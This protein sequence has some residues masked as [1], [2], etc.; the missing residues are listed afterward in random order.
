MF[1]A[2]VQGV[3]K[4][5][6]KALGMAFFNNPATHN[7][8]QQYLDDTKEYK[9]KLK[10]HGVL[11]PK[12]MRKKLDAKYG[13][14]VGGGDMEDDAWQCGY[15][16]DTRKVKRPPLNSPQRKIF[17]D[18]SKYVLACGGNGSGKTYV[19][20]HKLVRHCV[21]NSATAI[22]ISQGGVKEGEA[23][24]GIWEMLKKEILPA[25]EKLINFHWGDGWWEG[26]RWEGE[27]KVKGLN[28]CL[29]IE[30][31][32][33]ENS[34]IYLATPSSRRSIGDMLNGYAPDLILVDKLT[35]FKNS[36][37]FTKAIPSVQYLATCTPKSPR[38]WV[39]KIFIERHG[40]DGKDSNN[41]SV[42][43]LKIEDNKANL[44]N[45]FYENLL[46][47]LNFDPIEKARHL[48]GK[49]IDSNGK[50]PSVSS[51]RKKAQVKPPKARVSP[52]SA[53]PVPSSR[54]PS[55]SRAI[56]ARSES[57]PVDNPILKLAG[58]MKIG[59]FRKAFRDAFGSTL[60]VYKGKQYADDGATIGSVA[61]KPI[62]RG[63]KFSLSPQVKVGR[64]E[65]DLW[66]HFELRVQVR[67]PDDSEL[68]DN[69]LTLGES[70]KILGR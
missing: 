11:D 1:K 12:D 25:W 19:M 37:V 62:K 4:M 6:A 47:S 44:P 54:P 36:D 56:P 14:L 24:A 40:V 16:Q 46:E 45:G 65:Q 41:F 34:R 18:R 35:N 30:R 70:R 15:K 29:D 17:D 49:W 42:H 5:K 67:T 59:G 9:A 7:A 21:D 26:F 48:Q 39:Y 22:I 3:F 27:K 60:R 31:S 69:E 57:V 33:G 28:R 10:K 64:F 20:L 13:P 2:L 38:H 66:K 51:P 43:Q 58:R 61:G 63:T 8:F 50:S 55:S 68:V 32:D 53:P 23:L 52:V